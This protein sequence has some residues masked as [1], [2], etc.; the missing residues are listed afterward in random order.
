VIRAAARQLGAR[1]SFDETALLLALAGF[2][3]DSTVSA[4]PGA[5]LS[6]GDG[7]RA[8]RS[9]RELRLFRAKST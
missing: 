3:A 7:L 5:G 6:L 2:G 9:A 1:L 8:E 4:R